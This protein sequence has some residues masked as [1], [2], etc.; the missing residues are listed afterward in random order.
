MSS[1]LGKHPVI[2]LVCHKTRAEETLEVLLTVTVVE[3]LLRLEI[4]DEFLHIVVSTLT[5]QEF[6]S[7]NVKERDTTGSLTKVDGT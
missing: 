5:C 7:G 4:T 6:A 3:H 1:L 2:H